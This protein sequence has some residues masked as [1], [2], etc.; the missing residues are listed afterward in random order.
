MC[1]GIGYCGGVSNG[2]GGIGMGNLFGGQ[3]GDVRRGG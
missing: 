2:G 1:P 3:P